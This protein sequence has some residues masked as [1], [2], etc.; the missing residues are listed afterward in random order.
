M[1]TVDGDRIVP[2]SYAG[3]IHFN[4]SPLPADVPTEFFHVLNVLRRTLS[5]QLEAGCRP[6]IAYF[7]AFAADSARQ[8]F[9]NERLAV[10]SE[11]QIPNIQ[12][13]EVGLV[14]GTLDFMTARVIGDAPMGKLL[15]L[16]FAA[17]LAR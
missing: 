11:I 8:I 4:L 17:H 16:L 15:F 3:A 2:K 9:N 6:I 5:R 14:G 10:H 1:E 13:P 7:L 12:I